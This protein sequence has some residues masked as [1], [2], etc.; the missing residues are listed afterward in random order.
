MKLNL[1][2]TIAKLYRWV[3]ATSEMPKSLCP[4]FWKLFLMWVI[5][6]PYTIL[7]AP[8]M[9]MNRKRRFDGELERGTDFLEKPGSGFLIYGALGL[10]LMMIF[11]ISIFWIKFPDDSLPET[12]QIIGI[13]LWCV[14]IISGLVYLFKTLKEKWNNRNIRYDENGYRIWEPVEPKSDPVI[15]TFIKA[16]YNKYCPRIE[17]FNPNDKS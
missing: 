10:L 7:S 15:S 9:V 3:F 14:V 6:I 2:S 11:S 5:L 1:N 13:M 16:T 17:W 4:Y 8:Y 12:F